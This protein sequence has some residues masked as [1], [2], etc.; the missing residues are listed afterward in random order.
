MFFALGLLVFPGQL[1]GVFLRGTALAL[2]VALF[3]R[4]FFFFF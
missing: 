4:Y 3:A 1:G 2:F